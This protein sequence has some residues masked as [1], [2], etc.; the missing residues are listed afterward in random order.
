MAL[1]YGIVAYRDILW[2][3][4]LGFGLFTLF[5]L[6]IMFLYSQGEGY[7]FEVESGP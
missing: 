2:F 4:F 7:S 1:G 6:P 5:A 3:L